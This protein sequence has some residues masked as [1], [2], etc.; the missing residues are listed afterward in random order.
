MIN[1]VRTVPWRLQTSS[2]WFCDRLTKVLVW[3]FRPDAVVLIC[4]LWGFCA[5]IWR[6]WVITEAAVVLVSFPSSVTQKNSWRVLG[7]RWLDTETLIR[8]FKAG[9]SH[10]EVKMWVLLCEMTNWGSSLCLFFVR[11]LDRSFAPSWW[12]PRWNWTNWWRRSEKP[13][14]SQSRTGRLAGS[15]DRSVHD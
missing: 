9:F 8:K 14:R 5:K 2:F 12:R 13:W 11:T 4:N 1:R 7:Q 6:V 3:V 10:L 15:P